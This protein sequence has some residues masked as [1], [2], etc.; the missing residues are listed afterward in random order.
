MRLEEGGTDVLHLR[1]GK[2]LALIGWRFLRP[3][4]RHLTAALTPGREPGRLI[5]RWT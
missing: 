1:D 5:I 3:L 4:G 2:R